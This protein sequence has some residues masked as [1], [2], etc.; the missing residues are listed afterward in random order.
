MLPTRSWVGIRTIA[1]EMGLRR[2]RDDSPTEFPFDICLADWQ[3]MQQYGLSIPVENNR[4][5][6]TPEDEDTRS[7]LV[8][9]I[10][11]MSSSPQDTDTLDN[12]S[13]YVVNVQ[14]VTSWK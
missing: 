8:A 6:R 7:S 12:P 14:S 13:P 2:H 4:K 1:S 5:L 3:A 9:T 10:S 11:S